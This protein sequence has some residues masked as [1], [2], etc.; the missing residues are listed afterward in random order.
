MKL[1]VYHGYYGC[2]TGCC[3]HWFELDGKEFEPFEFEHPD[4][5]EELVKLAKEVVRR[6]WPECFDKID[7][8]TLD[9]DDAVTF[10]GCVL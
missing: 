5:R 9:V 7:W 10:D 6:H 8:N 3:G 1:R 2:D 4:T